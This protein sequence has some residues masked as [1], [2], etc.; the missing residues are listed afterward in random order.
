METPVMKKPTMQT[1]KAYNYNECVKYINEKH[2]CDIDNF[3][4]N[5]FDTNDN[6]FQ[7]YWHYVNDHFEPPRGGFFTL[8]KDDDAEDW[9]KQISNWF[10]EEFSENGK[11][12]EFYVDW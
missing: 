1:C 9:Q 7:C 5:K 2:K 10:L 11:E 6:T 3:T 12:V 4:N 8:Y